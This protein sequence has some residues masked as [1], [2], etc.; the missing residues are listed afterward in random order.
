MLCEDLGDRMGVD[1]EGRGGTGR[2]AGEGRDI[3]ILMTDSHYCTAEI[4]TTL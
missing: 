2:E 1:G 4:N 3:C